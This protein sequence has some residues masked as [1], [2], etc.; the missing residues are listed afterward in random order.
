MWGENSKERKGRGIKMNQKRL[1]VLEDHADAV[2]PSHLT[3][4]FPVA[5]ATR[6]IV[7]HGPACPE[8]PYLK[9]RTNCF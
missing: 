8:H 2:F 6:G 7:R 5:K 3:L 9:I 4:R 1:G